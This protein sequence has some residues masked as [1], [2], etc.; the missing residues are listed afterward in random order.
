L[1]KT[2]DAGTR[3]SGTLR[4]IPDPKRLEKRVEPNPSADVI[5][6]T[7]LDGFA[8]FNVA[9]PFERIPELQ[10]QAPV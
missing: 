7:V 9:E 5:G 3:C 1:Q 10:W 6:Q 8:A 4:D 2:G